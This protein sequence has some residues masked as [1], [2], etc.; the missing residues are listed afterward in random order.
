MVRSLVAFLAAACFLRPLAADYDGPV[1]AADYD[2]TGVLIHPETYRETR[3]AIQNCTVVAYSSVAVRGAVPL[4]QPP[5]SSGRCALLY[6]SEASGPN[7]NAEMTTI[8]HRRT[9]ATRQFS[10]RKFSKIPKLVPH[11]LFGGR[12]SVFFDTKL[13]MKADLTALSNLTRDTF[14]T[15]Y[16][17]PSCLAGCAPMT[18]ARAFG[19]P[20]FSDKIYNIFNRE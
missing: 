7:P 11:L 6:V 19:Q 5:R 3:L 13:R 8:V 17:H 14:L 10:N 4:V 18:C 9:N 1:R 12:V 20:N 16:K 15:A 2:V